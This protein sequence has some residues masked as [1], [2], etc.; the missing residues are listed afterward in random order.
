MEA[1]K[2]VN[3]AVL[4]ERFEDAVQIIDAPE[5]RVPV[6]LNEGSDTL[7]AQLTIYY[8][9]YGEQGVCFI[10]DVEIEAP[11]TVSQDG[12]AHEIAIERTI[13]PPDLS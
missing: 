2:S 1:H 8:C 4:A 10:D 9:R 11:V 6:T 7:M 13:T 3:V 12:A 5:L